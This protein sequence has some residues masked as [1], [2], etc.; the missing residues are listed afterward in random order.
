M[1]RS[2]VPAFRRQGCA[3]LRGPEG[4]ASRSDAMNIVK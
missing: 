3:L 1:Q 2:G 4:M